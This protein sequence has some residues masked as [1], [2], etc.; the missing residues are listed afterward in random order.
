M[1]KEKS[2]TRANGHGKTPKAI[3]KMGY[4]PVWSP[5]LLSD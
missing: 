4:S 3:K 1:G 5:I 2:K